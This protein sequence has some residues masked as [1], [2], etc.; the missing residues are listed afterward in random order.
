MILVTGATGTL[1]GALV[2]QLCASGVPTRALVRSQERTDVLRGYDCETVVGNYT[3]AG[4]LDDALKGADAVFV[5]SPPGPQSPDHEGAV[6]AAAER[7]GARIVKLGIIGIADETNR[8]GRFVEVHQR[9]FGRL[10]RSSVPWTVVAPNDLMQ[11]LLAVAALVQGRSILPR[12]PRDAAVS[13]VDARDVAAVAAHVLTT[14][15]HEGSV[16]TVTGPEA[17]TGPQVAARVSQVLGRD[18]THVE[19]SPGEL[20]AALQAAGVPE[21]HVEGLVELAAG[22]A[23]GVAAVVTDEVRKATGREARSV[24]EFVADHRNAF[25]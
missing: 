10:Q 25:A 20:R 19:R 22:Y 14:E 8:L 18:V 23:A 2:E 3:D 24:A 16:Y 5:L 21:W 9:S 4:S 12:M 11:N 13:S 7:A 15:G 6:I 1:G 17:L